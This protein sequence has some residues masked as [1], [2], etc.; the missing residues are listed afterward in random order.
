MDIV[1]IG[2]YGHHSYVRDAAKVNSEIKI[3]GIAPGVEGED[4]TGL[5]NDTIALNPV[6]LYDDYKIMLDRVKPDIAVIN[7]VFSENNKIAIECLNRGIHCFIE[8]PVACEIDDL[9]HLKDAYKSSGVHLTAMHEMRYHPWFATA[10]KAYTD[11]VIG[12]IELVTIQKSYGLGRRPEFYKTRSTYGGTILWVGMHAVDM[13]YWFTDGGI[14]DIV[15]G[16]TT[17]GNNGHGELESSALCFYR[18]KNGGHASLNID[19]LQPSGSGGHADDRMRIVGANGI[20]EVRDS[21]AFVTTDK[22]NYEL[23]QAE[24]KHIFNEFIDYIYKNSNFMLNEE[25]IF[26][27]TELAIR[28]RMAADRKKVIIHNVMQ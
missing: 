21:K 13:L 19:F 16:H 8:K 22:D 20:I 18:L 17:A 9:A 24:K 27:V 5:Y 25:E 28:S 2:A 10:Q 26:N 15:A 1:I 23:P 7:T 6:E 11:G 3:T 14:T 4:V 12:D